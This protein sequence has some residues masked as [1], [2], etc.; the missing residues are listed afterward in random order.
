MRYRELGGDRYVALGFVR[1]LGAD[2]RPSP[3]AT[4]HAEWTL[5]NGSPRAQ[6]AVTTAAGWARFR[7]GS[8][9][10][11]TYEICVTDVVKS[12]W[13]YDPDRNVE[14]C[15]TID[16]PAGGAVIGG[17]GGV[18]LGPSTQFGNGQ[19]GKPITYTLTVTNWNPY[20]DDFQLAVSGAEWPTLVSPER[21]GA[22]E[23]GASAV[24]HAVVT[25]PA[26]VTETLLESDSFT[27]TVSSLWSDIISDTAWTT[28]ARVQSPG[29]SPV[30]KL[31]LTSGGHAGAST[32]ASLLAVGR[33]SASFALAPN[34]RLVSRSNAG[35]AHSFLVPRAAAL[36]P[37][38]IARRSTHFL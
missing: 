9:L 35:S 26:W 38:R 23:P 14:T 15:D 5:P 37:G 13:V 19:E 18:Q 2:A 11:G 3:G 28:T 17:D 20:P 24:V 34:R 29:V 36:D 22:L 12:G 25:V 31:A 8:P 30:P 6:E 27:V 7:I 16:V 32:S 4:V 10:T 21:T 33:Q 1:I